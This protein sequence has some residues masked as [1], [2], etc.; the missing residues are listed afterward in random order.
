MRSGCYSRARK[1]RCDSTRPVCNNCLRRSNE[2]HYD[3]VPK[4]RGPD[5]RPG[6]R[7]RSCKKRPSDGSTPLPPTKRKRPARP[8]EPVATSIKPAMDGFNRSPLQHGDDIDDPRQNQVPHS[9]PS[10]DLATAQVGNLQRVVLTVRAC[11]FS[12][13]FNLL[14]MPRLHLLQPRDIH[15]NMLRIVSLG[16]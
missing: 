14:M 10:S 13:S 7:Q 3:T 9:S 2:C 12:L 16:R 1:I 6:T 8:E 11:L 15:F 5:K 4:R